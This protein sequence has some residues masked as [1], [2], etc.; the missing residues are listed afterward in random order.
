MP[1]KSIG[2]GK[3]TAYLLYIYRNASLVIIL[4]SFLNLTTTTKLFNKSIEERLGNMDVPE[5][6]ICACH[7]VLA[8]LMVVDRK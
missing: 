2:Y 5:S 1:Q 6:K 8:E 3:N 7:V 4:L